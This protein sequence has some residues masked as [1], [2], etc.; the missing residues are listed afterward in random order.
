MN[1]RRIENNTLK[2]AIASLISHRMI[3][4]LGLGTPKLKLKKRAVVP[5]INQRKSYPSLA[6]A[7]AAKRTLQQKWNKIDVIS[8]HCKDARIVCIRNTHTLNQLTRRTE[9]VTRDVFAECAKLSSTSN[10]I[11]TWYSNQSIR[12]RFKQGGSRKKSSV[13]RLKRHNPRLR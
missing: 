11:W 5:R 13:N 10:K 1:S 2:L 6:H 7:F 8:A 9:S 4:F 12:K 3:P